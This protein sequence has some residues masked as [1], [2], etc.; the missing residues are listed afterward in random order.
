MTRT[1][2]YPPAV[3]AEP[4]VV[5]AGTPVT[6]AVAA[7]ARTLGT[8]G[9]LPAYLYDLTALDAH[10]S[11]VRAAFDATDTRIELLHA[12]KA[13]PD[14]ELLTVIA[15]HVHGLEVASGGE[16]AHVRRH[17]PSTPLAFGGPGKTDAELSAALAADVDCYHVESLHEARRLDAAARAAG[18]T[19]RVLLR[20][21]LPSHSPA[22]GDAALTM[23]GVPSPFGMD[24]AEADAVATERG[25]LPGI[26]VIG[27]HAH[28][29][30]GH[31]ATGCAGLAETVLAWAGHFAHR[32]GLALHQVNVGG[33]MAVDYNRPDRLFDWADYARRLSRIVAASAPDTGRPLTV[34]IEPGRAVSAYCGWYATRILDLKRSQGDWFAVCAGGTHHLRTPAAKG[35]DQPLAVLPVRTWDHPW[36]RPS[37]SDEAITF[38]GQLCTP[39]DVLARQV[40]VPTLAVGDLV[41]FAMA[42]AYAHNISHHDFL[43]HPAPT[44]VHLPRRR[45]PHQPGSRP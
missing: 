14:P 6:A 5:P 30:S 21:N 40:P 43:M 25:Q 22:G 36:A 1:A 32:H 45:D 16:L 38:V 20:V 3:A 8:E 42:G 17:L 19:A 18:R 23:G 34:R 10:V 31:D 26:E 2:P 9:A 13:N 24:P 29:A 27:I 15:R 44:V 35:H 41:V 12:V 37:V 7:A 28:L 11:A 4:Y 39:K 33:G